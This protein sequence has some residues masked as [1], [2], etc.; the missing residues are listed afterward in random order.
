MAIHTETELTLTGANAPA[1][2]AEQIASWVTARTE[3]ILARFFDGPVL[4]RFLAGHVIG[5]DAYINLLHLL[6]KLRALGATELA[7]ASTEDWIRRL[8]P[9]IDGERTQTF[10]SM[11]LAETLL[12]WGPFAGNPLLQ[13]FSEAQRTNLAD[14]CDTTHLYKPEGTIGEW[15]ANYWMVLTRA[16]FA[17]QRLGLVRDTAV[18][19]AALEHCRQLLRQS[20]AD[21]FDDSATGVGRYDAYSMGS[22]SLLQPLAHLLPTAPLRAHLTRDTRMLETLAMENG[23]GVAWGRSIGI[24]SVIGTL[25]HA[26]AALRNGLSQDPGRLL[27]LAANAWSQVPDSYRD[28]LIAAHRQRM[29]DGYRGPHRLLQMSL[30]CLVALAD[31]GR[32]LRDLPP[33]PPPR[34][35]I[36]PA[37]DELIRFDRRN[38][39]VWMFRNEHLTFQLPFV[40]AWLGSDY[41][42]WP[43]SPGLFEN[44][45]DSP[46]RCGVPIVLHD[47]KAFGPGEL[48]ASVTK[49][50]GGLTLTYDS[51]MEEVAGGW[52]PNPA[53]RRIPA[54]LTLTWQVEG[55]TLYFEQRLVLDHPAD[56]LVVSIPQTGCPLSIAV[57]ECSVPFRRDTVA[58][59]GMGQYRSCWSQLESVH[60]IHLSP[61]R[62]VTLRFAVQR[63]RQM[64]DLS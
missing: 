29:T 45:V 36:F 28:D 51:L 20:A 12:E 16:E 1:A 44:P 39:G 2:L 21:Y 63:H 55:D 52:M 11:N 46:M 8:L 41:V 38:A 56:G 27:A 30:D 59:A 40:S 26:T 19:E 7:G 62:E 58:V 31:V 34:G 15:S 35:P 32:G 22:M 61:A 43:H 9:T 5:S 53:W 57:L 23:A 24:L 4:P 33:P 47:G 49:T 10:G 3:A 17:R 37:R 14:A 50:P 42:P 60:Q 13:G 48:P 54:K 6:G 25:G 18:L 64:E